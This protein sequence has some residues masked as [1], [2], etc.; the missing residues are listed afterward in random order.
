MRKVPATRKRATPIVLVHGLLGFDRLLGVY[1]YF[2]GIPGDLRS[3]GAR[4]YTANVSSSNFSEVRG[5]QL[6]RYLD[7]IKAATGAQKFN[8]IGHS[9]GGPTARY[10][11]AV[12]PDLVAS[13][14]SVGAPMPA[15]KLLTVWQRLRHAGPY[16]NA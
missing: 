12:R 16:K 1:D 7:S 3:G 4:V 8:L 10:V 11:A 9:H 5:E 6:I 13:M 15:A 2:Y 14:T